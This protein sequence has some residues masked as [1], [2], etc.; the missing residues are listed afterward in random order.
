MITKLHKIC[1][2]Q[3]TH[4]QEYINRILSI[5]NSNKIN[6]GMYLIN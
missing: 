6:R 4:L 3:K 2:N 5:N 1:Y